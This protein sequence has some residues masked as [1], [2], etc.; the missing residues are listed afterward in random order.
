MH[1]TTVRHN[2]VFWVIWALVAVAGAFGFAIIA[3]LRGEGAQVSAIWMIV[4]GLCTYAVA[5]RFYSRWIARR[6][7]QLDDTR[8]TRPRSSTTAATSCRPT[9]GCSSVI[10]SR[11]SPARDR[12]SGPCSPRSSASS[13][14]RSGSSSAWSSRGRCRTSSSSFGLGAAQRPVPR[15]DGQGRDQPLRGL[16]GHACSILTDHGPRLLAVLALVVVNALAESPWGIVRPSFATMPIAMIMGVWMKV[17]R[18]GKGARG[19]RSSGASC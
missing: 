9:G 18:H 17:W 2:P 8:A 7:L 5:Y 1:A 14:A 3:G 12:S 4:A 11:P 16:D 10:T 19:D 6:V 15:P 13:P